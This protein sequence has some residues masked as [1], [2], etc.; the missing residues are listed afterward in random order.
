MRKRKEL[1]YLTRLMSWIWK[2]KFYIQLIVLLGT[3]MTTNENI[4]TLLYD[5]LF[6]KKYIIKHVNIQRIIMKKHLTR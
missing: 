1:W 5:N 3:N 2:N 6:R 4:I